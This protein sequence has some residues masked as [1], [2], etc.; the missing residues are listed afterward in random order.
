MENRNNKQYWGWYWD[1]E[2]Y[3]DWEQNS[4]GAISDTRLFFLQILFI[5][6]ESS[7]EQGD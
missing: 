5:F 7:K 6:E 2:L 1:Q 3:W 4:K